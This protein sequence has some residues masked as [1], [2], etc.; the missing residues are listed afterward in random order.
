MGSLVFVLVRYDSEADATTVVLGSAAVAR[1]VEVVDGHV[2]VDVDS[3]GQPV[4]IEILSA[5]SVVDEAIISALGERFPELDL[6]V[7][8]SVLAGKSPATA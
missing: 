6:P 3:S 1:M 7:L 5:P 8:R 4:G 2:M